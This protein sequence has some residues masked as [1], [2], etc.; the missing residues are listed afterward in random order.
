MDLMEDVAEALKTFALVISSAMNDLH[1]F[2]RQNLDPDKVDESGK[3]IDPSQDFGAGA[4]ELRKEFCMDIEDAGGK[5]AWETYSERVAEAQHICSKNV[6][7]ALEGH[8]GLHAMHTGNLPSD[9][10][11]P[12]GQAVDGSNYPSTAHGMQSSSDVRERKERCKRDV[13]EM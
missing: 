7:R 10:L 11:K 2:I 8:Y 13:R 4:L 6:G 9:W 5:E 1:E 12:G 3:P